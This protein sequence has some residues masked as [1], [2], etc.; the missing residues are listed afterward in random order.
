MYAFG[1]G[2]KQHVCR[3]EKSKSVLG[4][5]ETSG[6]AVEGHEGLR[7]RWR[8]GGH[9]R[10]GEGKGSG[11][12]MDT[13]CYPMPVSPLSFPLPLLPLNPPLLSLPPYNNTES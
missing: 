7:Q 12:G 2:R 10:E 1:V 3:L 4:R 5:R 6:G 9:V 13:P 11:I 8:E